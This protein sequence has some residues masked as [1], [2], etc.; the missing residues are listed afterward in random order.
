MDI[1]TKA[2]VPAGFPYAGK[3]F[4][5][6]NIAEGKFVIANGKSIAAVG[7]QIDKMCLFQFV[8][9]PTN[10]VK[11]FSIGRQSFISAIGQG[12]PLNAQV[13]DDTW[14][15]FVVEYIA[16]IGAFTIK[17]TQPIAAGSPYVSVVGNGKGLRICEATPREKWSYFQPFIPNGTPATSLDQFMP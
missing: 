9:L 7:D 12:W 13:E 8:A 14:S 15:R 10:E 16:D 11:I 3:I 6:Q 2:N 4:V 5:F 1:E 17:S